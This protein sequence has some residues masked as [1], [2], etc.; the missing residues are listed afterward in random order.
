ME[1]TREQRKDVRV[2]LLFCASSAALFAPLLASLLH[3]VLVPQPV[4]NRIFGISFGVF[5][6]TLMFFCS[7]YLV[8]YAIHATSVTIGDG[9][10]RVTRLLAPRITF[11]NKTAVTVQRRAI[12]SFTAAGFRRGYFVRSGTSSFYFTEDFPN[13]AQITDFFTPGA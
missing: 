6:V 2:G 9:E 3:A 10:L 13:Y 12:P 5:V 7:R 11:S 1:M 4:Q 8:L